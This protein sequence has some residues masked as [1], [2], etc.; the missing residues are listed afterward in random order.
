MTNKLLF[1]KTS[2]KDEYVKIE[3]IPAENINNIFPDF[4]IENPVEFSPKW[5]LSEDQYFYIDLTEDKSIIEPY[6][7]V[8]ESSGSHNTIVKNQFSKLEGIF[9][10][11]KI[12]EHIYDIKFQR[13]WNKFYFKKPLLHFDNTCKFSNNQ[14][15]IMLNNKTDAYWDGNAKRLYFKNFTHIKKLFPGIDQFYREAQKEDIEKFKAI[16]ILTVDTGN[17][18]F[19]ERA[20]R[21][22][23]NMLDEGV[24]KDK[25]VSQLEEY[26]NKYS[27]NLPINSEQKIEITNDKDITLLYKVAN[28]LFYTSEL[29]NEKRETNSVSKIREGSNNE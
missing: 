22:I 23:A 19:G 16:D 9:I 5:K 25:T 15:T 7:G 13:I 14:D 11:N 24:F 17:K 21:K 20:R 6:E 10:G 28:E 2:K 4:S 8:L 12:E 27:K 18:D 3:E 26:A 29:T 1:G